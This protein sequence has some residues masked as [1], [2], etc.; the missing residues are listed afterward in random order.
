[1]RVLWAGGAVVETRGDV[2]EN[3]SKSPTGRGGLGA[4]RQPE[5]G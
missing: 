3:G 1:M 5:P 2:Q 4:S